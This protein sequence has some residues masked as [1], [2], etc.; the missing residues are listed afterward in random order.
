MF[1]IQKR[2]QVNWKYFEFYQVQVWLWV[3]CVVSLKLLKLKITTNH[4]NHV[5]VCVGGDVYVQADTFVAVAAADDVYA[6]LGSMG[7]NAHQRDESMALNKL[8]AKSC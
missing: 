8:P 2:N 4:L 5:D 6:D 3:F 1:K 7:Q